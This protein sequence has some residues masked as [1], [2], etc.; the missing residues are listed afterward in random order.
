MSPSPK[1]LSVETAVPEHIL[2]Q[3][4]TVA[5]A[6]DLFTG[7]GS[8]FDRLASVFDNAGIR[9]RHAV[10]PMAW[11]R[12]A[13]D[14]SDRTAAYLEGADTLFIAAATKAIQ[15]ARLEP[16]DI[17]TI[18]TISSTGIATPTLEV[19]VSG[20]MGFRSD[21]RRVPVFGLGCAG[22]VSGLG[23]AAQLAQARPGT[24][25]L[26]VAIEL[27]TLSF[28]LDKPTKSNIV[29]AALFGDGAAACVLRADAGG[30]L[31]EI[32]ATGEHTW[33]ET[34]DIMGWLVD[35]HG[36]DVV[37]SRSIPRFAEANLG[38]AVAGILARTGLAMADVDRF[39]C[40]PGGAKVITALERSLELAEGALDHERAVLQ[41]YGNMSAP[42][43]LFVL[44]RVL[45]RGLPRRVVLNAMGPGFTASC[46]SLRS[47]S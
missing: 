20:V 33:N 19:R 6:R 37:F 24:N 47:Q 30:G 12:E 40:H 34:L 9:K 32:E 25:V 46:V 35:P 16:S 31:A 11:F 39:V 13:H 7:R 17:D 44:E 2:L 18:L 29:A 14:W 45:R 1:L 36:L 23:L 42:T 28:R 8:E 43:V 26:M 5:A 38:P 21:V 22:G 27:C 41:D 3:T 4:D 10:R 15:A